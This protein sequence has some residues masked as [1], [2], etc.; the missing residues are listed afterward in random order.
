MKIFKK[1]GKKL[2]KTFNIKWARFEGEVDSASS[3]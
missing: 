3:N 2:R 1:N